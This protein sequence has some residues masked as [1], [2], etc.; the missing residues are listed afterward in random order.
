MMDISKSLKTIALSY[1]LLITV[2]SQAAAPYGFITATLFFL[3]LA[4]LQ[5]MI[6]WKIIV[7]FISFIAFDAYLW[8]FERLL[9]LSSVLMR[10]TAQVIVLVLTGLVAW[11]MV[12]VEYLIFRFIVK[13]MNLW[14]RIGIKL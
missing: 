3:L 12:M 13:K 11:G 2:L 10:P 7:A 14:K 8:S 4:T 5:S 6:G 1:V 9:S